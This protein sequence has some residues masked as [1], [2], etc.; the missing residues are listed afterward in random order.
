MTD[1]RAVLHTSLS[2]IHLLV[3]SCSSPY[4]L[5][6]L[7][8]RLRKQLHQSIRKNLHTPCVRVVDGIQ[9][10]GGV[11]EPLAPQPAVTQRRIGQSDMVLTGK[12][13]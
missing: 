9:Q 5:Y 1:F 11:G 8:Q 12:G 6:T 2:G 10:E 3:E 4:P 13:S 7:L